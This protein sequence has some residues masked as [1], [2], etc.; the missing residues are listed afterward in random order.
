RDAQAAFGRLTPRER[1]V[2]QALADGLNDKE[3]A[4]RLHISS[5]TAR[6]HMV[7]ILS[8]LGVNSRLQ[9]LVFAIRHRAVQIR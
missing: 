4:Q 9:A 6:T 1:E 7:N 2:L 8:K 5:E 3:I